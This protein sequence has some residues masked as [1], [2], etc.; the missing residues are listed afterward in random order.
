MRRLR[1]RRNSVGPTRALQNLV[2]QAFRS[3]ACRV[4]FL[5][6]FATG[7]VG[8]L[9]GLEPVGERVAHVTSASA[10]DGGGPLA[11]SRHHR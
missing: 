1:R 5:C 2:V 9:V 4:G 11:G 8:V 3:R 6:G 10:S 7:C